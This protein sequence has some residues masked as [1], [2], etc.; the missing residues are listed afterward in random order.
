MLTRATS[1]GNLLG[2]EVLQPNAEYIKTAYCV[3]STARVSRT[4]EPFIIFY[5]KG[6]DGVIRPAFLFQANGN[7]AGVVQK[8]LTH[9]FVKI[10]FIASYYSGDITLTIK[11]IE[12]VTDLDE[13]EKSQFLGKVEKVEEYKNTV[14]NILSEFVKVQIKPSLV[15]KSLDELYGGMSGGPVKF[16]HEV[17]TTL[18][19]RLSE[20]DEITRG[21]VLVSAYYSLNTYFRYLE[22]GHNKILTP[23]DNLVYLNV[24]THNEVIDSIASEVLFGLLLNN[25]PESLYGHLILREIQA[26]LDFMELSNAWKGLLDG[27]TWER[28]GLKLRK[29]LNL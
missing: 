7:G 10:N 20:E 22:D 19:S 11:D 6:I 28:R 9:S 8:E 4:E 3:N 17:I 18:N 1:K 5:V 25:K 15:L 23:K 14:E 2:D 27:G 24:D 21:M 13:E 16:M 26:S 12:K 29:Y